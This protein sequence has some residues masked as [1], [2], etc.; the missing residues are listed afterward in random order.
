M[1]EKKLIMMMVAA[2]TTVMPLM[3]ET[4]KVGGEMWTDCI[5]INGDTAEM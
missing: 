4:E 5:G 2:F 3:A 1:E